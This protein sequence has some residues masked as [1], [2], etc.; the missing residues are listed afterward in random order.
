M[1]T[2]KRMGT[3]VPG[4][5]RLWCSEVLHAIGAKM[6]IKYHGWT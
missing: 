6:L 3:S 4:W 2:I 5:L 1:N